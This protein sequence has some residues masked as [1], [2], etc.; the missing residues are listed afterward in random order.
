MTVADAVRYGYHSNLPLRVAIA[1]EESRPL[2]SL[3][4]TAVVVEA[5]KSAD[6]RSGT[7]LRISRG[8]TSTTLKANFPVPSCFVDRP[9]RASIYGTRL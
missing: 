4:N 1:E 3:D 7:L 8:W 9:A 2:I 5:V 6:D